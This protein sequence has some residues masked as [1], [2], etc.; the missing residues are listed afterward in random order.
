MPIKRQTFSKAFKA[1]AVR[2]LEQSGKPAAD[3]AGGGV[4]RNQLYKWQAQAAAHGERLS[5][6]GRQPKPADEL[7]RLKREL[8]RVTEER[9]ILK[10]A[11]LSST[12]RRNIGLQHI[13]RCP[14]AQCFSRALVQPPRHRIERCLRVNREVGSLRE[15]L[16]KQP[17]GI[18]VGPSLPRT[19]G[20]AKVDLH[21]GRHGKS[22]MLGQF[23]ASI[24]G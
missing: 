13:C 6:S 3:L 19:L 21:I 20:I 14:K 10:K 1:E 23:H 4:R 11:V 18:F 22:L 5:G 17:V 2:L 8:A 12:G 15:I 9:D 16:S 7:A 24:P